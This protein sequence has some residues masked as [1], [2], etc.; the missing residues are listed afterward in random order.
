MFLS[1]LLLACGI[2]LRVEKSLVSPQFVVPAA[3]TGEAAVV[4]YSTGIPG[5][6]VRDYTPVVLESRGRS[7]HEAIEVSTG[8]WVEVAP[9]WEPVELRV[10]VRSTT[11]THQDFQLIRSVTGGLP[12]ELPNEIRFLPERVEGAYRLPIRQLT[13]VYNDYKFHHGD[14]LLLELHREGH[15]TERYLFQ[16]Y[17]P[18]LRIKYSGGFLLTVPLAFAGGK[19][20]ETTSPILAFTTSFG[21]RLRT[22]SPVLRWFGGN[23]AFIVSTGVGSTALKAPSL[24]EPIEDQVTAHVTSI[25]SGGGFEFYDFFSIQALVNLSALRG[26]IAQ[27]PWVMAIGFDPVRFG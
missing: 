26:N 8:G 15:Q 6:G 27:A 24:T 23:S 21:W 19:M 13:N 7:F 1:L 3:P 2:P 22:R 17:E 25:I 12:D 4:S 14:L 20:P 5:E 11:G 18:G 10:Y 9:L 16:D